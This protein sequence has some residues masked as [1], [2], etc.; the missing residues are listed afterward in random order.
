MQV[1][2]VDIA[3]AYFNA[4]VD[5][6]ETTY[7]ALPPEDKGSEEMCGRLVR[8][9]CGTRAAADGW[10]EECSSFLVEGRGF[11]QGTSSPCVFRHPERQ[12]VASV[13]G[14]DFT[15]AGAKCDLDWYEEEIKKKY[16]C[17]IQPRIGPGQ[18]DAKEALVL[19][20]V[21]RWTPQGIEYEADPRQAEKLVS[22]CGL[23]GSNSVA[24]PGL[25]MSHKEVEEDEPLD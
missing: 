25:R 22:E 20:R 10:Q 1:S 6:G 8:H 7:V 21:I 11:T 13:H 18:D 16:E 12:L 23:T 2:F 19:N 5:E 14:D 17:T 3:R 15:T 4:R 9:M 24:T